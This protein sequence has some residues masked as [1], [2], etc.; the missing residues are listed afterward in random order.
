[1]KKTREE[2]MQ[3][4]RDIRDFSFDD[5]KRLAAALI[6][7][8]ADRGWLADEEYDETMYIY[9]FLKSHIVLDFDILFPV[10]VILT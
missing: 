2:M 8:K 3:H 6:L 10:Q 1:M 9:Q 4:L 5:C 7:S